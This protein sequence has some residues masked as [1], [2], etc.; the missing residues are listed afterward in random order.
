M[1]RKTSTPASAP[2]P[3]AP[4]IYVRFTLA[5]RIQHFLTLLSF[6]T[7]AVTGLIQKFPQNPV[8]LSVLKSFGGIESTRLVHHTAAVILMLV[9]VYHVIELGYKLF[10]LRV[11]PTMLP[12]FQDA[13]D[14]W[15]AFLYNLG[16]GKSRPQMGRYT[17]EEK[18]E[19]WALIWGILIMGLTGFLMWNP[20]LVTKFLPGEFIP[21]AKVAHGGEAV[22]AV[23]AIV[24]WHM[25]GVHIK[26]FNKSMFVG[27]QTE[28]EMLEEHPLELADIKAGR[29]G[30]PMDP[31][32]LRKR[33]R[34]Y[35]PV[36]AVLAVVLLGGVYGFVN[37]EQTALKTIPPPPNQPEV[38]V[39]QT[40]TPIPTSLPTSTP[41][42]DS[43][44]RA[45]STS[46][47][48]SITWEGSI[49]VT[50]QKCTACH[51]ETVTAAGLDLGAY[52]GTIEGAQDGPVIV[53]GDAAGSKLVVI[54]QA[55]GHPG[56]L[57]SDELAAVIEWINAGAPE[58]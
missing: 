6:I 25:Y 41:L 19:Y 4:R 47:N 14:A 8:S 58:R 33:Q 43:V 23:L 3:K 55:G 9:A 20:I 26:R 10:V 18:A 46:S 13:K 30:R 31:V 34:V 32:T 49:S 50:L 29:P 17:F 5:Q 38:F 35:Y 7:L 1:A 21:A 28:G 52:A 45:T 39:P 11:R 42:P 57:T 16:I 22:L 12:S 40:L 56:E 53:P 36:A 24:V 37:G 27:Y 2:K 48:A 15:M 54:Q 51:G 44:Q